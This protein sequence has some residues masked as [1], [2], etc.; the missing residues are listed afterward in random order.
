MNEIERRLTALEEEYRNAQLPE[1]KSF[2]PLPDGKYQ[3]NVEE[4][5]ID[6]SKAG[7]LML[8]WVLLI[9]SG[10]YIGRKIFKHHMLQTIDNLRFLKGDLETCGITLA[11][12]SDLPKRLG[13]LLDIKLEVNVKNK[14]T[15]SGE[16]NSNIYFNFKLIDAA[17]IPDDAKSEKENDI[18]F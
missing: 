8:K 7:N 14:T 3:V 9:I 2:D 6:E 4:V 13:E 1:R 12:F 18:P 11:V 16:T 5:C 10:R 17:D 15:P